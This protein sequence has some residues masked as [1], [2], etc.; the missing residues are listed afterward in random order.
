MSFDADENIKR[1]AKVL[2]DTV[3]LARISGGDLT[4]IEAKYHLSCLTAFRKKHQS[5]LRE[6][7]FSINDGEQSKN[8]AR[9]FM[10]LP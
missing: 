8:E 6:S 7:H 9:A 3:L 2:Q 5:S 10:V 1:M 4:A